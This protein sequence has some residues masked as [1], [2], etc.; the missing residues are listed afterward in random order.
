[1]SLPLVAARAAAAVNSNRPLNKGHSAYLANIAHASIRN[2]VGEQV[3]FRKNWK[4]PI[5]WQVPP[6]FETASAFY[7]RSAVWLADFN[8]G[9]NELPPHVRIM[10]IDFILLRL[11]YSDGESTVPSLEINTSGD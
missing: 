5:A 9:Y 3:S 4:Q 11:C 10:L 6:I 2:T 7:Q 8:A 1:M